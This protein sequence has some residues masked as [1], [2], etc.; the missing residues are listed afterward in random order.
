MKEVEIKVE[1]PADSTFTPVN[2]LPTTTNVHMSTDVP[3][4]VR[5]PATIDVHISTDAAGTTEVPPTPEA[6]TKTWQDSFDL[7]ELRC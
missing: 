2:R 5:V 6:R 4:T 7:A 3:T 1:E